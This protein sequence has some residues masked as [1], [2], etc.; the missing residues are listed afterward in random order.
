MKQNFTSNHLIKYL[1]EETSA[2]EKLAIDEALTQDRA[3]ADEYQQLL[4]A[5][6]Q[7]PKVTFSVSPSAMQSVLGYSK[8]T[9][10]EKHA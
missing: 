1:Y 7:L 8:R 2:S 4:S 6:Q 5:Y 9:A 10:L 3:L